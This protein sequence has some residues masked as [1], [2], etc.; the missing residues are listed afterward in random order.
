MGPIFSNSEASA[1]QPGPT[2]AVSSASTGELSTDADESPQGELQA[3]WKEGERR[4]NNDKIFSS[5]EVPR[6]NWG[7][8]ERLR[9]RA[10]A[11]KQEPQQ[12]EFEKEEQ[13]DI[14]AFQEAVA[15]RMAAAGLESYTPKPHEDRAS[16]VVNSILHQYK[17][18]RTEKELF[19]VDDDCESDDEARK[20][21]AETLSKRR[22]Q[23]EVD[24]LEDDIGM[25]KDL[26]PRRSAC[27]A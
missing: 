8:R 2:R 18:V 26:P 20:I 9:L 3:R 11:R 6:E 17:Q 24:L 19:A 7:K 16:A 13:R 4:R 25:G 23:M 1:K 10:K 15:Y 22:L 14:E 5:E 12:T 27:Q 21:E